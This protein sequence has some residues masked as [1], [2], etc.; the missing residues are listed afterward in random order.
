MI[1]A[2]SVLGVLG[3]PGGTTGIIEGVV[4][5]KKTGE[6]LPGV[7]VRCAVLSVGTV[8]N[9]E[10]MFAL[11]NVRVGAW[12]IR[13]T[14]IGYQTFVL[15]NVVVHP[16]LRT[17]L[18]IQLDPTAVEME[19]VVVVQEKPL[20]Q[21]DITATAF[22]VS[23]ED[24]RALPITRPLEIV[25]Y[26]PGTTLEGN[27]R[28]GK[29]TEVSYLIDGLP[30][31]EL[32]RGEVT[33][34]LPLSSIVGMSIHTGG[35]EAQYGNALSGVVNIVTRTGGND[36]T[37]FARAGSDHMVGGRQHSKQAEFE[38]SVTGPLVQ[39]RLS[40]LVAGSGM[41]SGTR[42][43]QDMERA[44]PLPIDR[45]LNG[46]GK[47]DYVASPTLRFGLQ[48]LS[49]D[50]DWREYE[51]AWRYNL[52]GIP[53]EHRTSHRVAL[54]G[55]Q[56]VGQDFYYSASLSWYG[57]RTQIG[58]GDRESVRAQ[59]PYQYDFFLRYIT[60]GN[61][62]WWMDARQNT[63][64]LKVDASHTAWQDHLVKFGCE[65][66]QYDLLSDLVKLEPKKTYFG[67][68]LVNEPQLDFSSS[69]AYRPRTGSV[70]IQDKI[71]V[72][73]EGVLLTLGLRYDFLDP[74]AGRPAIETS[75][76]GDTAYA[77]TAGSV[78]EAR[79]K[80][81]FSPRF[82]AAMPVMENGFLF[83]N[84]GWYFQHP[85]FDYLYTGIDRVAL[86]R[87]VSALTGNPDLE[88]E[89]ASSWEASFK[90]ALPLD[91]VASIAYF[92]KESTNLTDSKTFVP[93]DSKL[94]GSYGFAEFV[95]SP[96]ASVSGV[97]VTLTRERGEWVTGEL[98]Y[99]YMVAEGTSGSAYDGYYIAQYGLPPARR[100]APLS[101]DQ[102]HTVK[103]QTT[104]AR[105]KNFSVSLFVQYHSGRPYTA[106][107]TSTGFETVNGGLFVLN[108]ARMRE[109]MN[110]DLR[111]EKHF[112]VSEES[113]SLL[114]AFVDARNLG[115]ARN[116]AW[117]DSNS[118][119]GGE[120]GDPS[121]YFISRRFTVGVQYSF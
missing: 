3:A 14:H 32:M 94:A 61:R 107:P 13:F 43:W 41:Q 115:N 56:T 98:S 37:A 118:R 96:Y 18:R 5:D 16:D 30:V 50:R 8:T 29:T 116:V 71:D 2:W 66:N 40:F 73:K 21:T 68:P 87:G 72:L 69:Y 78:R 26:K 82:G 77:I 91:C 55:S 103:L 38:T 90:Y 7:N 97:E 27:V 111:A 59:Q 45:Q 17:R 49:S 85:L 12:E 36:F 120:L 86:G 102:R 99:T 57:V 24:L 88:P 4:L 34:T 35:F 20:I 81:Q 83:F 74:R 22:Q 19:E 112:S 113:G 104:V 89:R 101:W 42:W 119:I 108:N 15:R 80:H 46:F 33:A 65:I 110:I 1:L 54:M 23:G 100:V 64:T 44:F 70:Y 25:G 95:N 67:K 10:G 28:G 53:P 109:Y 60:S 114:T 47:L 106:Y 121:G 84:L 105:P 62:S 63:Y 75:L 39:D 79:F 76:Q 58:E 9:T 48:V 31:Q 52:A 117:M 92:K 51:F 11:H 6:P 93:G